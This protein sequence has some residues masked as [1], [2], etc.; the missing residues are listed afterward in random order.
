MTH[1]V[2]LSGIWQCGIPGLRAPITLPGTLDESGVGFPDENKNAWHPAEKI[3]D[4]M[5]DS[6]VIATRLTRRYT[7]EGEAVFRRRVRT[8]FP[9]DARVFLECERARCLRLTVNGAPAPDFFPPTI[10]TPHVFEVTG[11]LTGDDEFSLFSDNSYPGLPHDDIL[12]SSAATD[13]TQ[14]NWNGI[15]GYFRLRAERPVFVAQARALPH[16]AS[17][18]VHVTLSAATA[19]RG[20][21]TLSG[22]ALKEPVYLPD[23]TAPVGMTEITCS[24]IPLRP[25]APR[26]DEGEGR[27]LTLTVS[28]DHLEAREIRFGLRD[29]GDDGDG[30]LSLNGRR[31]FLRCEANCCVFPESGHAP[32]SADAWREILNTYRSYGV[33][34]LRF[35]SH[36]PP[37]AAFIAADETGMLMQPELSHWNPKTALESAESEQYYRAELLE[38]VRWLGNH[39]SFVMMTLGNELW[40]GDAGHARMNELLAAARQLDPTRLYANASNAHYGGLGCDPQSDFYTADKFFSHFLRGCGSGMAGFINRDAPSAARDY[41]QAMAA[42]RKTYQKPVFSFEVGQYEVLPDFGELNMF[43]GV[44]RP[45]N[46]SLIQKRAGEKR[47][48]GSWNRY[49]EATGELALLCYREE[50]EAALRTRDFSGISLLGL[51]DFPG[52]G[53]AL[54]GML[55]SHLKPKPYP[56]AQPERFRAF[57]APVLPLALLPARTWNFGD[58]FSA[59]VRVAN[60]GKSAFTAALRWQITGPRGLVAEGA[61]PETAVPLG[62][63]EPGVI[64]CALPEGDAAEQCTLTLSCGAAENRYSLWLYPNAQP[65]CP[66]NVYETRVWD[67]AA[68]QA[69]AD[70][71]T[72]YLC[73]DATAEAMPRSI[74]TQFS[75]DFWSVGTFPSQ[76]GGMGQLI[77][78]EHP[79]FRDFPTGFHTDWQWHRMASQRAFLLPAPCRAIVTEMDSCAYLRPMAQLFE[80]RCLRGKILLSSLNLHR[81]QAYPEC[82]A[83]QSTICRYLSSEK[84]QPAEVLPCELIDMLFTG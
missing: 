37:E 29:F 84:F 39:P 71:G 64:H 5:K 45:D 7:Y 60:Y 49:C 65:V 47:L 9:A 50:V 42:I 12:Y 23:C 52:Q 33:N 63:S 54:V 13:E 25:D 66:P 34:C 80:G 57:F 38:T 74:P 82:R 3:N 8:D 59:P 6:A 55:N 28:G 58:D 15:L 4:Q 32:M 44:T 27:L 21:L 24:N 76:A 67:D 43:H 26:W 81:L 48:L 70:G 17:V 68:K 41:A 18:D 56:F 77:D 75:T 1:F 14:T 62:V 2:D 30:H 19:W 35:H 11:L 10:S 46:L 22:D 69:L 53:T 83:L 61:F 72:V 79:L 51:Q 16:G 20:A 40:A 78:A 73:P 36:V 31:I